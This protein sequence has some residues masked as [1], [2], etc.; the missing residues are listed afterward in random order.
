MEESRRNFLRKVGYTALG[1]G[2]GVPLLGTAVGIAKKGH[3]STTPSGKKLAMVI[4]I[5]KCANEE[6]RKACTEACHLEHNVPDIGTQ[7]EEV[8]WIWSESFNHVF[9]EQVHP[10]MNKTLILILFLKCANLTFCSAIF[11][12][13]FP[14][15]SSSETSFSNLLFRLINFGKRSGLFSG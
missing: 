1:I 14:R 9:P 11:C 6:L 3:E 5:K 10:H 13:F 4:D 12:H 15:S 2:C 7:K 8:K